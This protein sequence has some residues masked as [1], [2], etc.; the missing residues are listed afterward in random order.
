[1]NSFRL[2]LM[3]MIVICLNVRTSALQ[4][5]VTSSCRKAFALEDN[6]QLMTRWIE[7]ESK[8]TG[9]SAED[10]SL[11]LASIAEDS[12]GPEG[13]Y[14]P[15]V[16]SN[17]MDFLC[18]YGQTNALPFLERIV[19]NPGGEDWRKPGRQAKAMK[20]FAKIDGAGRRS[21]ELAA[22]VFSSTNS[23]EVWSFAFYEALDKHATQANSA[24]VDTFLLSRLPK[25]ERCS[26]TLDKILCR[27]IKGYETSPAR[28]EFARKAMS[29]KNIHVK[30][31]FS[32]VVERLQSTILNRK[33]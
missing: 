9:L 11:L 7:R 8:T 29:G 3:F 30:P 4:K 15:C 26:M 31:H 10:F 28:M 2:P 33:E 32:N 12:I 14:E 5:D 1:M 24:L 17:A 27:R 18:A 13:D 6:A 22:R 19:M 25:E 20:A 23:I 16:G 21:V